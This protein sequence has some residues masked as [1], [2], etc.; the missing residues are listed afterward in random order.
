MDQLKPVIDWCKKNV[1]WIVCFLLS[2]SLAGTF[3]FSSSQLAAA[4][5]ERAKVISDRIRDLDTIT[6]YNAEPDADV[7]AHPNSATQEGMDAEINKTISAIAKAWQQQYDKQKEIF[8]WPEDVLGKET[9]DFFSRVKVVE[10]ISDPGKGFERF[11]KSYY[12]KIPKFMT[13]ICRELGVNWQ[14]DPK[15]IEEQELKRKGGGDGDDDGMGGPGMGGPG[16]GG[17]G[18]GGGPGMGGMGMGGGPGMGGM[19]MGASPTDELNKYPVVWN[20]ENQMLWYR[21]LTE[22]AGYDDHA[23]DIDYPTFL[24]ANMLQQD[25][26]LLEAM[27]TNIKKLNGNSSSND[28][29][30]IRRIDHIVFG[31]E[32]IVQLGTLTPPDLSLI[33][34]VAAPDA[35]GSSPYGPGGMGGP[36][37]GG[38]SMGGPGMGMN[39]PGAGL[40]PGEFNPNGERNPY[41]GRYVGLDFTPIPASDVKAVIGGEALPEENLE[42][43]VAKRVPFRLAVEMDERKIHEF[44]AICANSGF[45]FEVNQVRVNR[46]VANEE[47]KFNGGIEQNSAQG[48]MGG[49]GGMGGGRGMGMGDMGMGDMGMGGGMAMGGGATGDVESLKSRNVESRTNFDVSVE[50]Y[51]IIR[52]YNPVRENFLRKAAGQEVVDE[53]AAEMPEDEVIGTEV[54]TPDTEA[55]APTADDGSATET[56]GAGAGAEEGAPTP[57]A[58]G[59]GAAGASLPPPSAGG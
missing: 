41:H 20:E 4:Q 47:I 9:C 51:G 21:K 44:I 3:F 50:F 11:R 35:A 38:P 46:H 56:E 48:G 2:A 17:M 34:K 8:N 19:G 32:A 7:K 33:G 1:F 37:M 55:A 25:L 14:Y 24:Q 36:G 12:D 28:T 16:M 5:K 57:D 6:A 18:M 42:L 53:T 26:W 31:R 58:S 30:K 49:M 59:T 52:I 29:S 39:G 15:Y 40:A 54:A 23:G 43:I 13:K 10:K 45:V 27:F 22:F